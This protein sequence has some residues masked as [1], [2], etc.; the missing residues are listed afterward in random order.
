MLLIPII[1]I[2]LLLTLMA[3]LFRRWQR[4]KRK[5]ASISQLQ[6]W[7]AE[8]QAL[9]PTL[10]KW[11]TRLSAQEAEVLFDLLNGYCTSLNWELAWLFAPQIKKAPVLQ[12]LLEENVSAYARAILLS[13]QMEEDVRAYQ[14]Y[15]T[16]ERRPTARSQQTLV[17]QLYH[18]VDQGGLTPPVKRLLGRFS[19]KGVTT[20]QQVTAIQQAF[21][22]DPA[23]AM[24]LLKETLTN[25]ATLVVQQF[26]EEAAPPVLSS[27]AAAA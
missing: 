23:Q 17:E 15:V 14:A 27:A 2:L 4:R 16:F 1:L 13:L 11:M 20:K 19:R 6:R 8:H 18:K 21:E 9:D 5:Q 22:R 10:Q 12:A 25:D 7:A 3:T 24:E 26:R